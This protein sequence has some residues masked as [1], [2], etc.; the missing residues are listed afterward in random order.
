MPES[1]ADRQEFDSFFTNLEFPLVHLDMVTAIEKPIT[2]AELWAAITSMQGGKCPGPDGFP[3]EFFRQFQHKLLPILLDMFNESWSG[4]LLLI[5]YFTRHTQSGF[6]LTHSKKRPIS[7]L[8]VDFK[9][10]SKTLALRLESVLPSI[11]SPDQTRFI[12]NRH[13]FFN[14]RRLFN[15]IYHPTPNPT[16]ET[17]RP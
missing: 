7:L 1:T 6:Y 3:V 4:T 9:L 11:I 5:W 2:T 12:K 17:M 15:T 16:P 8:N 14:L 13:S 10:Q